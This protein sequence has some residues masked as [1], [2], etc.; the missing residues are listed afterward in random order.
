MWFV[1]ICLL[2][3]LAIVSCN[4]IKIHF[5]FPTSNDFPRLQI[6]ERIP[7]L[8][9]LTLCAWIKPHSFRKE[10]S[11]FYSYAKS[12]SDNLYK[13]Y[14]NKGSE[15]VNLAFS[16][17][18]NSLHFD[19]SHVNLQVGE[20]YHVCNT[21]FG[22]NGHMKT[23]VNGEQCLC[24]GDKIGI[25]AASTTIPP[26]GKFVI[27]QYYD[28]TTDKFDVEQSFHG[29]IADLNLWDE[30]LTEEQVKGIGNCESRKKGGNVIAGLKTPMTALLVDILETELCK[31]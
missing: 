3:P 4:H 25:I 2:L 11:V 29:D 30:V 5:P 18:D 9:E 14:F 16:I 27:G 21:W 10:F 26:D 22:K 15:T 31:I 28:S 12:D 7:T 8:H 17:G 19:C 1:R 6:D 24:D 13:G 20:W 23:Y